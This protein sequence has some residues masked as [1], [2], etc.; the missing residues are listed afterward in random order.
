MRAS[1]LCLL[2]ASGGHL[3]A[4]HGSSMTN[5]RTIAAT[6]TKS[7][8]A[9]LTLPTSS[10]TMTLPSSTAEKTATA[11]ATLTLPTNTKTMSLPSETNTGT[12]TLPAS[13]RTATLP[14]GTGT[15]TGSLTLPSAFTATSTFSLKTGTE[16]GT[17]TETVQATATSS[18][19]FSIPSRTS[20]SSSSL[21]LP[22]A[23]GSSSLTGTATL[24]SHDNYTTA[25]EPSSFYAGQ[26]IRIQLKATLDP[27][28]DP[29]KT[30]QF[31]ELFNVSAMG[32]L[33]VRVFAWNGGT[34]SDCD[35]YVA[36][37]TP[38]YK[39][40]EFGMTMVERYEGHVF[41][42]AAHVTFAAP[43]SNTKFVICFKHTVN[44]YAYKS[45]AVTNKWMIFSTS[46]VSTGI[47]GQYVFQAQASKLFYYLPDPSSGQYAIIQLL[48]Q[49]NWNFTY[50][51]ST[52][53]ATPY[54][55]DNALQCGWGDNLKLVPA[56]EPCT[57]EHQAFNLPYLG[58]SWVQNDGT[59]DRNAIHG[60]RLGSTAGGA[61][62]FGT[63]YA[64]PLVDTWTSWGTYFP[65]NSEA[66]IY[67][68]TTTSTTSVL[69]R[70]D[71]LLSYPHHAYVYVR[72]PQ[73]PEVSYDVCFSG[74]EQRISWLSGNNT[75]DAVP[76]W[77]KVYRCS[78]PSSCTAALETSGG[79]AFQVKPENIGW[80]M[81]DL[82]PNTWGTIVFDDKDGL[83]SNEPATSTILVN[84]PVSTQDYPVAPGAASGTNNANYWAPPGGDYFRIVKAS[85]F[86][87]TTSQSNGIVL[88]S[89][90]NTGC[91]D[92]SLDDAG[93]GTQI[94]FPST[95]APQQG[96]WISDGAEYP[97]GSRDLTG[98]PTVFV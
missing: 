14:S 16:T 38:L 97:I 10:S 95:P 33:Q 13:T 91:W 37:N 2:A 49:E 47:M 22:T 40:G 60:L 21:T 12:F 81:Y 65:A 89:F 68:H 1:V 6:T 79:R 87:E 67:S 9:T 4:A 34:A 70:Q 84:A 57:L 46:D 58:S 66:Y 77:R 36:Q 78:S 69:S 30:A 55:D 29:K 74:R 15:K 35:A 17:E 63:Q 73:T 7:L 94:S 76:M 27:F 83:L 86:G 3:A 19:T 44:K 18:H 64:N 90:P 39:T 42:G 28:N 98:D 75:L 53:G 82:T 26:E 93:T 8:E 50:A 61:G 92:R 59:W 5:T 41:V 45:D 85:K 71:Y 52:C 23:T 96:G 56:G 24:P 48:S 43:H 54:S 88:G 51:P 11:I 72:L 20:T 31:P 80:S 32:S 25:L 62:R